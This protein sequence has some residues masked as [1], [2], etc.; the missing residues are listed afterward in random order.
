MSLMQKVSTRPLTKSKLSKKHHHL[1]IS[2]NSDL[3]CAYSITTIDLFTI[4]PPNS[5]LSTPSLTSARSGHGAPNRR[6]PSS[7]LRKRCS[8]ILCSFT[9]TPPNHLS[10]HVMPPIMALW[11][12]S[13]TTWIP[14]KITKVTGPL[15]YHVEV[16]KGNVLRRH[17]DALRT[18]YSD[19]TASPL[20]DT[21]YG[22]DDIYFPTRSNIPIQ[23]PARH[24][25]LR[26]S[27]HQRSCPNYYG[28]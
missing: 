19:S 6:K 13:T 5:L 12:L 20:Q 17:V 11:D 8:Q 4:W 15:S 7:V 10:W 2:H 21:L 25:P 9:L 22:R 1:P 3:F 23:T 27:T 26:Q 24:V 16:D 28:Q 14:G 18:R